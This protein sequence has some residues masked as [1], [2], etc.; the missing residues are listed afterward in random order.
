MYDMDENIKAA[1]DM[2]CANFED[3]LCITL[4]ELAATPVLLLIDSGKDAGTG[5][6]SYIK[7]LQR[8]AEKWGF[9]IVRGSE[10][11]ITPE[12]Y[13][14]T[15]PPLIR[16]KHVTGILFVAP[17]TE[18]VEIPAELDIDACGVNAKINAALGLSLDFPTTPMAVIEFISAYYSLVKP[19]EHDHLKGKNI[20]I[21]GRGPT[22]GKPLLDLALACNMTPTVLH[23]KSNLELDMPDH[24]DII[25]SCAGKPNLVGLDKVA[26]V[27]SHSYDKVLCINVGCSTDE[28]GNLCGDFGFEDTPDDTFAVTPPCGCIGKIT[29]L[30]LVLRLINR[31]TMFGK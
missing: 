2:V 9:E 23:S 29:T 11:G 22:V 26:Y 10:H 7:S 3:L 5:E 12:N 14:T 4:A 8:A 27:R 15:M 19:K 20:T 24:T 25:V 17:Q 21:I 31:T 16:S 30:M 1:T 13:R 6:V 28:E 18:P